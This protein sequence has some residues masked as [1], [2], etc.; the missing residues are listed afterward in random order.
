MCDACI[1][2]PLHLCADRFDQ[3]R[4][5]DARLAADENR[6]AVALFALFPAAEEQADLFVASDQ[7]PTAC[8]SAGR[9]LGIA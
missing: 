7:E 5:A 9:G 8:R 4:F 6:L 1:P 2:R 3:D